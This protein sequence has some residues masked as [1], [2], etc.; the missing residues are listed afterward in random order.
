M[1]YGILKS[2]F[3]KQIGQRFCQAGSRSMLWYIF[4]IQGQ[5]LCKTGPTG[6]YIA[7]NVLHDH[8]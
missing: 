2:L 3:V 6:M 7:V 1:L 4:D 5:L 8:S